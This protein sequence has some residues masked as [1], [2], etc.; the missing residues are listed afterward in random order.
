MQFSIKIARAIILE[1][2]GIF[3]YS[4]LRDREEKRQLFG[5]SIVRR[6]KT[7]IFVFNKDVRAFKKSTL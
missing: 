3:Y 1:I 5:N 6:R 2:Y 7:H 4:A